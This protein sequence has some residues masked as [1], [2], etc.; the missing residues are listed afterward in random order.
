MT[1]EQKSI[2]EDY[3]R[4]RMRV[5]AKFYPK[6]IKVIQCIKTDD[7]F[8]SL[9][10]D[11]CFSYS[12][13]KTLKKLLVFK[14]QHIHP[15]FFISGRFLKNAGVLVNMIRLFGFDI[16]NHSV[17]HISFLDLSKEEQIKEITDNAEAIE[18]ITGKYPTLFRFPYGLY[19]I[20]SIRLIQSLNMKVIHWSVDTKDWKRD[21]TDDIVYIKIIKNVRPGGIILCH[22]AGGGFNGVKKAVKELKRQGY[23]FVTVS[24]LL[25]I[26]KKNA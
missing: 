4:D 16:M 23:K 11:C 24:Q 1:D 15:T 10:V 14:I 8:V 26:E 18:K 25:E 21:I 2:I 12:I 7:K 13:R 5:M 6:D 19:G 17:S 20:N 3:K 9:T 22:L